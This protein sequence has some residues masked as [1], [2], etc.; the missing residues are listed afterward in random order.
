M[1]ALKAGYRIKSLA[2]EAP[3]S[4]Q[5]ETGRKSLGKRPE[6]IHKRS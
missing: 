5:G 3:D 1:E 4:P 2:E 6:S